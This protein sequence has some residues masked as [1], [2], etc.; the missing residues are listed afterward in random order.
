MFGF[1][2]LGVGDFIMHHFFV[3]HDPSLWYALKTG[4][5]ELVTFTVSLAV[6]VVMKRVEKTLF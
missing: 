1:T 4:W 3:L 2:A 5:T 6:L